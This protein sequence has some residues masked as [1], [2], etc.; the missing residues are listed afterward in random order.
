MGR[1]N[2]RNS[3]PDRDNYRQ[4][5]GERERSPHMPIKRE[6]EQL[7]DQSDLFRQTVGGKGD[8]RQNN[9]RPDRAERPDEFRQSQG[10]RRRSPV[11]EPYERRATPPREREDR[12]REP[13]ARTRDRESTPPIREQIRALELEATRVKEEPEPEPE[14][15]AEAQPEPKR[16]EEKPTVVRP[17]LLPP[18]TG[19]HPSYVQVAKPYVF[20]QELQQCQQRIGATESQE[21][22]KRLQGVAWIDSVRRALQL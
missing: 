3:L 20:E 14:V 12:R 16:E 5:Q 9:R 1:K 4:V 19:P 17:G 6:R 10:S 2:H 11:Y 18:N 21:D 22:V 15:K 7:P 13:R 8:K